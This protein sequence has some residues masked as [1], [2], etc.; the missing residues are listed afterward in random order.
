MVG[1]QVEASL[2]VIGFGAIVRLVGAV[3][4]FLLNLENRNEIDKDVNVR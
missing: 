3:H 4:F 2:L 1:L